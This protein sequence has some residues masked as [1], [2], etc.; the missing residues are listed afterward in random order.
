MHGNTVSS[1]G[2]NATVTVETELARGPAAEALAKVAELRDAEEIAVGS[3]RR[4]SVPLA[5]PISTHSFR[6]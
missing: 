2:P 4:R 1:E 3:R 6:F 5:S